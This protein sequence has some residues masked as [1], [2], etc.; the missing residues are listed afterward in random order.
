[1]SIHA[2]RRGTARLAALTLLVSLVAIST[3]QG[4]AAEPAAATGY[5][6]WNC[7]YTGTGWYEGLSNTGGGYTQKNGV[8]NA[9]VAVFLH[10][11]TYI[12]G[13]T[14]WSGTTYG[15]SYISQSR[16]NTMNGEHCSSAH[17]YIT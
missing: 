15:W 11:A 7:F 2:R 12:G 9:D 1:M 8:C 3:V 10:Y 14:Y 6:S 13:P 16:T 5:Q 4:V 17:C